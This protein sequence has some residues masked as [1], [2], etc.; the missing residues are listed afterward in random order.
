MSSQ[1]LSFRHPICFGI[2]LQALDDDGRCI[3]GGYEMCCA[4]CCDA[5]RITALRRS[6]VTPY[7]CQYVSVAVPQSLSLPNNDSYLKSTLV[8]LRSALNKA[9][10]ILTNAT[11]PTSSSSSTYSNTNTSTNTNTN[12]NARTF[13]DAMASSSSVAPKRVH[14]SDSPLTYTY[15]PPA[16]PRTPSPTWSDSSLPDNDSGPSTPP[17]SSTTF[18]PPHDASSGKKQA[19]P[20]ALLFDARTQAAALMWNVIVPPNQATVRSLRKTSKGKDVLTALH[21]SDLSQSATNPGSS[22]LDIR[23]AQLPLFWKPIQL[24]RGAS[25]GAGAIPFTVAEVI[26]A[27]HRYVQLPISQKEYNMFPKDVQNNIAKAYWKRYD[28]SA[29]AGNA[30]EAE[31]IKRGGLRRVDALG[32][33]TQFVAFIP[34]PGTDTWQVIL[35]APRS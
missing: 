23:I 7:L 32:G 3:W 35:T 30:T 24:R 15:T 34:A 4:F 10:S 26:E 6:G 27:V 2:S 20:N 12:T 5:I 33:N 8:I 21:P 28:A 11:A 25:Y 9:I 1:D 29:N 14:F 16:T 17:P 22:S 19:S 13:T 18:F 31:K